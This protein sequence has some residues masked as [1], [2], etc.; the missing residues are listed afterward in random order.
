MLIT[1]CVSLAAYSTGFFR[2]LTPGSCF[3]EISLIEPQGLRTASACVTFATTSAELAVVPGDLYRRAIK[4]YK[5]V[6]LRATE[7]AIA[8]IP[9]MHAL[10]RTSSRTS[11]TLLGP[12]QHARAGTLSVEGRKSASSC[13]WFTAA[14]KSRSHRSEDSRLWPLSRPPPSS[15]RRGPGHHDVSCSLGARRTRHV[16]VAV[17]EER[18][19]RVLPLA[20]TGGRTSAHGG[21]PPT[22]PRLHLP[23][24]FGRWRQQ[25]RRSRF[26]IQA[27]LRPP[28]RCRSSVW[29]LQ[30]ENVHA[31]REHSLPE[32]P[33]ER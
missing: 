4:P 26:S 11:R 24:Q 3:G 30:S 29:G 10:P 31:E 14:S 19:D 25:Q 13:C 20:S 33:R 5:Q 32:Y 17:S 2:T 1:G 7:T 28:Q 18:H 8:S 15:D 21:A 22:S 23:L 27:R 12:S 16:L 9:R 6:V